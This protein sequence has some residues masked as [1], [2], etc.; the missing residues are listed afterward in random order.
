MSENAMESWEAQDAAL[1]NCI[2]KHKKHILQTHWLLVGLAGCELRESTKHFGFKG[3]DQNAYMLDAYRRW[4]DMYEEKLLEPPHDPGM[5][6]KSQGVTK[7][8]W[9]LALMILKTSINR[10]TGAISAALALVE[11]AATNLPPKPAKKYAFQPLRGDLLVKKFVGDLKKRF[12]NSYFPIWRG[13]A[14]DWPHL[15][16]GTT[17][18]ELLPKMLK[19]AGIKADVKDWFAWVCLGPFHLDCPFLRT[20]RGR[21][22]GGPAQSTSEYLK[23]HTAERGVISLT[24]TGNRRV[25]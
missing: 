14:P 23:R 19:S 11:P 15:K 2:A 5:F 9:Q 25:T 21:E 13:V 10:K 20:P 1:I 6:K 8:T 18:W 4:I 16:S 7:R 22:R 17:K 3:A 24:S 12:N